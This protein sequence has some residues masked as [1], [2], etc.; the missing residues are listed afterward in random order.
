M[1]ILFFLHRIG[2][3]HDARFRA[4]GERINLIAVE[5]RP[6]S[7]EYPWDFEA[8][9]KNYLAEKVLGGSKDKLREVVIELIKRYQPCSVITT[10]WADPEYHTVILVASKFRLPR[11]IVSDSRYEDEPRVFYKEWI[12]RLI[13][14]SYSAALVAGTMS[15]NYLI[16]LGFDS[17]SIFAPWDVV[18]NQ[19]FLSHNVEECSFE[20]RDFLCVSRFIAKKNLSSLIE[21]FYY[22]RRE[23]GKRK[24][25]LLGSGELENELRHQVEKLEITHYVTFKGFVQYDVLPKFLSKSFCLILPSIT[26]QWGLV[27]NEAMASHIPVLV[28]NRCGCAIDIVRHGINGYVFDPFKVET[29]TKSMMDMDNIGESTWNEMGRASADIIKQWDLDNFATGVIGAV[30]RAIERGPLGPIKLVHNL[31]S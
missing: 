5:T 20:K 29:I 6:L 1:T 12:K 28:S 18:D 14:K 3:Y 15:R 21:A 4:L 16:Q 27:V 22:Y 17:A 7:N 26:D 9:E 24:L 23:G 13:L 11:I 19:Y 25:L 30:E 8:K 10:G 2:P 31:L